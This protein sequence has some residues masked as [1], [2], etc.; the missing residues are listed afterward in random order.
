MNL[1]KTAHLSS[2]SAAGCCPSQRAHIDPEFWECQKGS[3]RR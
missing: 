3:S 1:K 2:Y